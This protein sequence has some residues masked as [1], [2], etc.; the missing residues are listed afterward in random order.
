MTQ[1]YYRSKH[2]QASGPIHNTL[3]EHLVMIILVDKAS[4]TI[5]C[6]SAGRIHRCFLTLLAD[7]YRK[8]DFL[9]GQLSNSDG[10]HRGEDGMVAQLCAQ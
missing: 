7:G 3:T 2:A 6:H 1:P 9:Q 5:I 4:S 8:E 10:E